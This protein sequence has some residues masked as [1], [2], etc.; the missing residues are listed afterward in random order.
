MTL[1]KSSTPVRA[2]HPEISVLY[3][4]DCNTHAIQVHRQIRATIHCSPSLQHGRIA[5]RSD[6]ANAYVFQMVLAVA[7]FMQN[8]RSGQPNACSRYAERRATS[9]LHNFRNNVEPSLGQATDLASSSPVTVSCVPWVF[10]GHVNPQVPSLGCATRSQ[11]PIAPAVFG[12]WSSAGRMPALRAICC[13]RRSA[14]TP[15]ISTGSSS[16]KS[17]CRN[18]SSRSS[19]RGGQLPTGI[20]SRGS[21]G[22]RGPVET[23]DS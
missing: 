7:T 22:R 1:V 23:E 15:P 16:P 14:A 18:G 4:A 13:K 17:G 21:G 6:E 20:P 9:A 12:H 3:F 8:R 2:I 10:P 19:S 5:T 11:R